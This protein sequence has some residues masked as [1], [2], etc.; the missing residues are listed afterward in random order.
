MISETIYGRTSR[1]TSLVLN[2]VRHTAPFATIL[3]PI[4]L[5]FLHHEPSFII[6]TVGG[7]RAYRDNAEKRVYK[8]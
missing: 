3:S 8:A 4:R 5:L 1:R 6:I 2:S 7:F